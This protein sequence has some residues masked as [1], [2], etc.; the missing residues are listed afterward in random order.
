VGVALPIKAAWLAR[1]YAAGAF[2]IK[3]PVAETDQLDGLRLDI[4]D[5]DRGFLALKEQWDNLYS[6]QDQNFPERSFFWA[7]TAWE[8]IARPR[9]HRLHIVVAYSEGQLV[10]VLPLVAQ[11]GWPVRI[12]RWLGPE[13][14]ECSDVLVKTC[15][16]SERWIASAWKL[17]ASRF[18]LLRISAIRTDARIW[19]HVE[20]T[21]SR[22]STLTVAPYID[23]RQWLDAQNYVSSR[24]SSFRDHLKRSHGRLRRLGEPRLINIDGKNRARETLDWIFAEKSRRFAA[25]SY[26]AKIL[27][28]KKEFCWRICLEALETGRL[29]MSELWVDDDLI[30]AQWG[31]RSG[32]RLHCQMLAWDETRKNFGPGHLMIID[33][34]KW[35]FE[36]K[37]EFA[38]LGIGKDEFKYKY[39]D[40]GFEVAT[41]VVVAFGPFD[42]VLLGAVAMTRRLRRSQIAAALP[43]QAYLASS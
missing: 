11:R 41:D 38:E 15:D 37:I 28:T 43:I 31:I 9:G 29:S 14:G 16:D 25:T 21:R 36:Q 26:G 27:G 24:S 7:W 42:R 4:V 32:K 12:G 39:T 19:P 23:L 8:T 2:Q 22:E 3:Q 34:I 20:R 10:L 30:A 17:V 13:F 1:P 18:R 5:S 6:T 33:S 40:T 35:A